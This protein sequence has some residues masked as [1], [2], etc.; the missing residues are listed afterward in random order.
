MDTKVH[1]K[2]TD[3][4]NITWT[5]PFIG[6]LMVLGLIRALWWAAGAAWIYPDIAAMF[7]LFAGV[8]IG[9]AVS[10]TCD[11]NDTPI[12]IRKWWI[13]RIKKEQSK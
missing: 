12:T 6:P 10:V 2:M 13:N 1:D 11:T 4:I 8:V 9:V 5:L 3:R 7:S